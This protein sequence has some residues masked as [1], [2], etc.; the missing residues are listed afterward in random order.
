MTEITMTKLMKS[1]ENSTPQNL[2]SSRENTYTD[3]EINLIVEKVTMVFFP[4]ANGDYEA[5]FYQT[6]KGIGI[7][8]QSGGTAKKCDGSIHASVD[9]TTFRLKTIRD[10]FQK[11]GLKNGLRKF[12]RSKATEIFKVC[13]VAKLEGNL[14]KK[15]RSMSIGS[16]WQ[17]DFWIWASDFQVENTDCPQEVRDAIINSFPKTKS[18]V[19]NKNKRT[20]K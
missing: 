6:F 3:S 9:S 4:K 12:A 14:A 16:D 1:L 19:R 5:R 7:L 10:I 11:N 13:K 17:P 20:G 15:I 2:K 18:T 8:C